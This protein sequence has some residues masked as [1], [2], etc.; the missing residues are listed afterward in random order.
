MF[1]GTLVLIRPEIDTQVWR[2]PHQTPRALDSNNY[3]FK[4][5]E[6]GTVEKKSS[7]YS[8]ITSDKNIQF[9]FGRSS[10]CKHSPPNGWDHCYYYYYYFYWFSIFLCTYNFHLINFIPFLAIIPLHFS[11]LFL[12]NCN[13]IN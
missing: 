10:S 2:T 11:L 3:K 4:N 8:D 5:D 9:S 6:N 12:L 1:K 7:L 13:I